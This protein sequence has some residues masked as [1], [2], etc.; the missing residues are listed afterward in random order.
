MNEWINVWGKKEWRKYIVGE[1]QI[2]Y[3]AFLMI[4][5]LGVVPV[6]IRHL[7]LAITKPADARAPRSGKVRNVP[8]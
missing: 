3:I 1:W 5:H 2:V 7:K 4:N 8:F 6:Y